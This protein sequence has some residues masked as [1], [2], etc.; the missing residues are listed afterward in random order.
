MKKLN[1]NGLF[2]LFV[3]FTLSFPTFSVQATPQTTDTLKSL[4]IPYSKGSITLD[5]VLDDQLWSKALIVDLNLVNSP[6]NNL[7]SPIK[8]TAKLIENGEF[9]YVSFI[10]SDPEPEKIQGFMRD[11][12]TAWSEDLVG[13][14][15]DTHNNRRLNYEFF[16]NPYGVQN[17][18][19]FMRLQV[20]RIRIGMDFGILL[21][22]KPPTATRLKSLF[23]IIF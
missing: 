7:P 18:A 6:W 19:T 20:K 2:V 13:I 22:K 9:L 23:L 3:A 16:V 11:R 4:D 17:D 15:L 12:D 10:A 14:K 1:Y 5:G 8:T 21:V